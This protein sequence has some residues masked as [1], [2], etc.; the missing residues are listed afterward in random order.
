MSAAARANLT[1][2]AI[3]LTQNAAATRHGSAHN[4]AFLKGG[5]ASF[6]SALERLRIR[7]STRKIPIATGCKGDVARGHR[8]VDT[9]LET[10]H[11]GGE[12]S[13][14]AKGHQSR[15]DENGTVVPQAPRDDEH[16]QQHDNRHLGD[17]DDPGQGQLLYPRADDSIAET[18]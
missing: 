8:R 6:V 12:R 17:A 13:H 7:T 10:A 18:D 9:E 1:S 3:P 4:P 2:E 5:L 16:A 11:S 15:R 14:A